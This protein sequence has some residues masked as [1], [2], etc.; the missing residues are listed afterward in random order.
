[1]SVLSAFRQALLEPYTQLA[2]ALKASPVLGEI[3]PPDKIYTYESDPFSP[4]YTLPEKQYSDLPLIRLVLEPAPQGNTHDSSHAS[5]AFAVFRIVYLGREE[6]VL[7]IMVLQYALNVIMLNM[8]PDMGSGYVT[9]TTMQ[10]YTIL[11]P[12]EVVRQF[13]TESGWAASLGILAEI[14]IPHEQQLEA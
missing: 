4:D 2:N 11:T 14:N 1:M 12:A 10:D 8:G 6:S 9:N 13:D 7:A 3:V 5:S